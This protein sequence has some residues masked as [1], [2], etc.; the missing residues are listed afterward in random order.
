MTQKL[1]E[2]A[3]QNKKKYNNEYNSKK[4]ECVCGSIH[5]YD[6]KYAHMKTQKH[7]LFINLTV[8]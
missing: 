4:I 8:K 7:L 3:L 1:S 6:K 5:R 2:Q